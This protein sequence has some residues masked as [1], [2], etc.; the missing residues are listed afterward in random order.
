VC[1]FVHFSVSTAG[2]D[3]Y[4]DINNAKVFPKDGSSISGDLIIG[5]DGERVCLFFSEMLG[6]GRP[7]IF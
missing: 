1:Y 4:Q 6:L 7:H 3:K 5:A 2:I